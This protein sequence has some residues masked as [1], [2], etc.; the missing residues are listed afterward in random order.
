MGKQLQRYYD[1]RDLDSDISWLHYVV[2]SLYD[3]TN[4]GHRLS[5]TN[6]QLLHG[7]LQRVAKKILQII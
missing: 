1:E 5:T 3:R 6:K 4:D 2:V 7:A